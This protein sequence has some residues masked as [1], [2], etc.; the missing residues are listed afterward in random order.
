MNM[1]KHLFPLAALAAFSLTGTGC[2]TA[3]TG[4]GTQAGKERFAKADTNKDGKLSLDEV[5]DFLVNGVFA[6]VDANKDGKVSFAEWHVDGDKGH[7]QLFRDRDANNDGVVSKKE[8]LAYG[9]KK[10][11]AAKTMK[12]ADTNKDGYLTYEEVKAFYAKAEGPMH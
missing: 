4:P 10:G 6:N 8:A 11:M 5:N 7:D 9:K 2:Q 12:Q 3:A 1:T